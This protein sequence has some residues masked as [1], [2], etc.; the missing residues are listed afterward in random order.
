[1]KKRSLGEKIFTVFNFVILST[2]ALT[3]LLPFIN[4][5][6]M[7]L[8]SNAM[9]SSGDVGLIPKDFSLNSYAYLIN[10]APFWRAFGISVVR[11]VLGVGINM[12][13]TVT[14]AYPLSK[15]KDKFPSRTLYVWFFFFT[16]LLS[17]GLIPSYFLI[18]QLKLTDTIWALVL[19]SAVPVFN[20][21]LMLNFYRQVPSELEDAALIDGAGHWRTL[22]QIF[23]PCSLPAVATLTLFCT[24]GHWNAW[25][26]GLIYCNDPN[27]YPLQSYLQ[28]VIVAMDFSSTGVQDF[29]LIKE[30]SDSTLK[31]AQ[32]IIATLP[33]LCVYPFLQRY[34]VTGLVVGSVKG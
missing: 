31:S 11:V 6:A 20:I 17:G 9:V 15:S 3:C 33:I 34:F 28:N 25:F 4:V 22:W 16:T 21:I 5:L 1:M 14:I 7:S 23:L 18:N 19:P 30:L 26:D 2:A 8:S 32:I 29:D 13:L 10:K 12:L 27:N 24:V